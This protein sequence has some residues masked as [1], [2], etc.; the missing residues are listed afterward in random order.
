MKNLI[1]ATTVALLV[2]GG[3]VVA[4]P[5]YAADLTCSGDLA[6]QTVSGTLTV[7]DG[8]DC[9]IGGGTVEG[10]VIVE[11]GG[12][13][14][15]TSATITGD[16]IATDAYGVSI[17]GT[18][19]GGDVVAAS[20]DTRGGFLY[21]NDLDV[22]GSVE[23]EGIDVEVTDTA[24]GGSLTTRTASYVDVVRT[25]V[26]GDVSIDGS[27]YGVSVGGAVVKGSVTVSGSSRDVLIGA[28]ADGAADAFANSIGGDLNLTDNTANLRVAA[29]TVYGALTLDG[30]TPAA[31]LGTGVFAG[32]ITGDHTGDAPAQPAD[33]DQS[34]V[35]TVPEQAD[36]EFTWS[37][38]GT[39][40]LVDLGIAEEMLDHYYA[41]GEIVPIRIQDTRAGNPEWSLTAQVSD[42]TAGGEA[43][44]SKYLGWTPEVLET[45]GSAIAGAAIPSGF[46]SGD[47]LSVARTLAT[48]DEGHERGS[49]LVSADLELKLPLDTP[50]GTYTAT[51]TLTALS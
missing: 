24:I 48:A 41:D 10:D 27:D 21:L 6:G 46:D 9:V 38:E 8:V 5:A 7:P 50:R 13:L 25:S 19:V 26:G 14:D 42:F 2:V 16:V 29:T 31:A 15:A 30:N 33:G 32:S 45:E 35:V 17:D 36:G 44:S 40:R 23:A 39:S 28:D 22:A 47:G 1:K 43:V 37:I 51:I 34:V 49:S 4:V 18:S 12:W 3:T 20:A 11:P